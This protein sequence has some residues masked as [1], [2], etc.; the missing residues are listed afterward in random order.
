MINISSIVN[1][2]KYMDGNANVIQV[3]SKNNVINGYTFDFSWGNGKYVDSEGNEIATIGKH[4]VKLYN[5]VITNVLNDVTNNFEISNQVNDGY[6]LLENSGTIVEDSSEFNFDVVVSSNS[7]NRNGIYYIKENVDV[8]VSNITGNSS[9]HTFCFYKEEGNC[10]QTIARG[11]ASLPQG[12]PRPMPDVP[13][14][15]YTF[16][17]V[18]YNKDAALDIPP[19]QTNKKAHARN[20]SSH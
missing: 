6:I 18:R 9:N 3:E 15:A 20:H 11:D 7:I 13:K 12:L 5:L 16:T 19:Q 10:L 17:P 2:T 8:S 4:S 14:H 1:I